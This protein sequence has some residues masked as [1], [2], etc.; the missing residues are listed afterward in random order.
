MVL[1]LILLRFFLWL[2]VWHHLCII[3]AFQGMNQNM[4]WIWVKDNGVVSWMNLQT[5][6]ICSCMSV[7]SYTLQEYSGR[8]TP[9]YPCFCGKLGGFILATCSYPH[10]L[11]S[12][13]PPIFVE[14][15]H[16]DT[17]TDRSLLSSLIHF[18]ILIF[19]RTKIQRN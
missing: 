8:Y 2:H 4:V 3:N 18:L 6:M 11:I 12:H 9:L 13:H 19:C 1:S 7:H 14:V 15:E 10:S 17:H 16:F 5:I